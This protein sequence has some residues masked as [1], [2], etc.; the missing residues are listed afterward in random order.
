MCVCVSVCVFVFVS[1]CACASPSSEGRKID[2]GERER[3]KGRREG[4]S[5]N[6]LS[7]M[8]IKKGEGEI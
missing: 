3:H 2:K 5:Y 4:Q 6:R 8:H 1:V 7:V